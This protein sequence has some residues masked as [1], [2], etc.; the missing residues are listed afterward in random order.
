MA[1]VILLATSAAAVSFSD[2]DGDG[3][4]EPGEEITFV[5][6][7]YYID[8]YNIKQEYTTWDWDFDGDGLPDDGGK[9]VTHT[10]DEEGVYTVVVTQYNGHSVEIT[11]TVEVESEEIEK[12]DYLCDCKKVMKTIH[13]LAPKHPL[14]PVMLKLIVKH[15]EKNH[16]V[17]PNDIDINELTAYIQQCIS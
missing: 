3:I 15:L 11:L 7:D 9:T 4:C 2:A 13:H 6:D 1:T 16:D 14:F 10:F 17:D 8:E 5:G 12:P